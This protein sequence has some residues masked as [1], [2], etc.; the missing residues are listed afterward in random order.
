MLVELQVV[1]ERKGIWGAVVVG[2]DLQVESWKRRRRR[3]FTGGGFGF[4][5]LVWGWEVGCSGNS[6]KFCRWGHLDFINK[7]INNN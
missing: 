6:R 7:I 3:G 4:G 5:K 2:V 1:K